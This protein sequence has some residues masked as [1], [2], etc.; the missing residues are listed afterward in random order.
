VLGAPAEAP[1]AAP[2]QAVGAIDLC[3]RSG[4]CDAVDLL[5]LSSV[6]VVG[7]SGLMHVAGAVGCPVVALYGPTSPERTPPLGARHAVVERS[8]GCRPCYRA[9]CPLTHG[10]CLAAI[11]VAEVRAAIDGLLSGATAGRSTSAPGSS[12][13]RCPPA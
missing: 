5:A 13:R 7:D 12:P 11:Q 3:G 4:L 2:L 6:A 1:L 10:D 9:V 8:L